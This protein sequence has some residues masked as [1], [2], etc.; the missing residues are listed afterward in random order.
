MD[1]TQAFVENEDLAE[2]LGKM[3]SEHE[4]IEEVRNNYT[5]NWFPAF[6]LFLNPKGNEKDVIGA[7]R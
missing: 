7:V 4:A 5:R 3:K 1:M 2:Q 6:K